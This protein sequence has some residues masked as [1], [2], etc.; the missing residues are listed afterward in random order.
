MEFVIKDSARAVLI[1]WEQQRAL[2]P[3]QKHQIQ[4]RIGLD[5]KVSRLAAKQES[6][7]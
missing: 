3:D 7:A 2:A 4:D 1:L 6:A 5:K